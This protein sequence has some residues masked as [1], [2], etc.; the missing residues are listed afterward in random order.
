MIAL[1]S[2]IFGSFVY[3]VHSFST[4][5]VPSRENLRLKVKVIKQ[6]PK[7]AVFDH[8]FKSTQFLSQPNIKQY[9]VQQ[10]VLLVDIRPDPGRISQYWEL[11]DRSALVSPLEVIVT[12]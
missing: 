3:N 6:R 9:F 8:Q 2:R 1:R 4:E 10:Q 11:F 12:E 7:H 5:T